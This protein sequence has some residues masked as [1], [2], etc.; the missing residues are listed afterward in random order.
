MMFVR[1]AITIIFATVRCY[2]NFIDGLASGPAFNSRQIKA[3]DTILKIDN[4]AVSPENILTHL[5][6]VDV[7]GSS[8]KL[9][10]RWTYGV[11]IKEGRE[12]YG[13]KCGGRGWR[14]GEGTT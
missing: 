1:L 10:V 6:G 2:H 8:V 7:P 9:L 13:V 3:G 11:L 5:V 4:K 14:E 12:V